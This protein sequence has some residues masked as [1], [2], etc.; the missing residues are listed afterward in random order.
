MKKAVSLF[1]TALIFVACMC[2]GVAIDETV[3]ISYVRANLPYI[4]VNARIGNSATTDNTRVV[5][6]GNELKTTKVEKYDPAKH[7][8]RI[9]MLIDLST[10][11][12]SDVF[13][14][15]KDQVNFIL[16]SM[17]E[18]TEVVLIT[19][20]TKVQNVCTSKNAQELE[21][22]IEGLQNDEGG[23]LF[24]AALETAINQSK[25]M[26]SVD[27]QYALVFSDGGDFQIGNTTQNEIQ[28][29]LSNMVLPIYAI[30]TENDSASK[31]DIN[32]FR[33][34]AKMSGGNIVSCTASNIEQRFREIYSEITNQYIISAQADSNQVSAKV[35]SLY[36][37]CENVQSDI[38]TI[39]AKSSV[40]NTPPE[41][42][43]DPI[44]SEKDNSFTFDISENISS[45][46]G[47][48]VQP[49]NILL[50]REDGKK[51]EVQEVSVTNND[52]S[53]ALTIVLKNRMV[54]GAYTIKLQNIT[55]VSVEK[56]A[57]SQELSFVCNQGINPALSWL[58][59]FWYIFAI[60]LVVLLFLIILLL[61]MK[62]KNVKSIKELFI[63]TPSTEYEVKH[64]IAPPQGKK[65]KLYVDYPNGSRQEIE[66]EI[67][68]SAMFGR[69]EMCN[70]VFQDAKMSRQ[71]F[72]IGCEGDDF[73]I[74]DLETTNGTYVNGVL[75]SEPQKLHSGD[76]IFAGTST[77]TVSF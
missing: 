20:G 73:L 8:T 34:I 45:A 75:I 17:T 58:L 25:L 53:Y 28:S 62:K 29:A 21:E 65:I 23:T 76:K 15:I 54:T 50:L 64:I 42:L 26:D 60:L 48:A 27:M 10:S 69:S 38:V 40:D 37:K 30:R 7:S 33:E 2:T 32:T 71:H 18:K 4:T 13:Q 70:I 52:E 36:I 68:Q 31:E 3:K 46:E 6:D 57:F 16:A 22:K 19:F 9:F 24:F 49:E 47:E 44:I 77:I 61:L 5:M 56:N 72:C 74:T 66:T 35:Q 59:Q 11:I 43:G 51:V 1:L 67:V 63:S 14:R 39:S 55:D 41:F 12:E